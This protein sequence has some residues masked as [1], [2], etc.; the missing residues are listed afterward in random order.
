M[1][2]DEL[3]LTT[4]FWW[5][6]RTTQ[7][8]KRS[9]VLVSEDLKTSGE[10]SCHAHKGWMFGGTANK[11]EVEAADNQSKCHTMPQLQHIQPF[12][13]ELGPLLGFTPELHLNNKVNPSLLSRIDSKHIRKSSGSVGPHVRSQ[14]RKQSPTAKAKYQFPE[15]HNNRSTLVE[16]ELDTPVDP[17]P[18]VNPLYRDSTMSTQIADVRERGLLSFGSSV[19]ADT[20]G[21]GVYREEFGAIETGYLGAILRGSSSIDRS[22]LNDII[23]IS[24]QVHTSLQIY[25]PE[26]FIRICR[27]QNISTDLGSIQTFLAGYL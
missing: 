17:S 14:N 9:P 24:P 23:A 19:D 13:S 18:E 27:V 2:I 16:S 11:S 12:Q 8:K 25:T 4:H 7:G 26:I 1:Q 10:N 21:S 22:K 6:I 3:L 20:G 15:A 5:L